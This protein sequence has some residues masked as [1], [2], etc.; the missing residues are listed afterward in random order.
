MSGATAK[1]LLDGGAGPAPLPQLLAAAA[2]PATA[3][4][5][6][7]EVAALAGFR[8]SVHSAPLPDDPTW[9]SRVR[10]TSSI[11]VV[12]AIAAIALT[13]GT[14]GGIALATTATPAGPQ[15]ETTSESAVRVAAAPSPRSR[16]STGDAPD[17]SADTLVGPTGGAGTAV[18]RT[19]EAEAPRPT[20]PCRATSNV[21]AAQSPAFGDLSCVVDGRPVP[22]TGGPAGAPGK[23][24][25]PGRAHGN[26][27]GKDA[28]KGPAKGKTPANSKKP[29]KVKDKPDKPDKPGKASEAVAD[30]KKADRGKSGDYRQ[31][32]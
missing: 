29:A 31:D 26:S 2:A 20:G 12:K 9:R 17:G 28:A 21:A 3:A 1:R 8:S 15:A 32:G 18:R 6:H 11:M 24:D 16:Q 22:S 23:P 19:P 27:K 13:A 4:E 30:T 25:D 5:L 14:A 10:V 7:G